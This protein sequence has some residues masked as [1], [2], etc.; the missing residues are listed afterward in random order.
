MGSRKKSGKWVMK[1]LKAS[2]VP[3]RKTYDSRIYEGSLVE[4]EDENVEL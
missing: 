1:T 3:R 2:R 4:Q